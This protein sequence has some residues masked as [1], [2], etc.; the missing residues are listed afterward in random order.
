MALDPNLRAKIEEVNHKLRCRQYLF[1]DDL[2]A[3][4]PNTDKEA[5]DPD[6]ATHYK[7]MWPKVPKNSSKGLTLKGGV[8]TVSLMIKYAVIG[9]TVKE[10][11]HCFRYN[12]TDHAYALIYSDGS[13]DSQEESPH[14]M[15]RYD[16]EFTSPHMTAQQRVKAPP[17][18]IQVLHNLPRFRISEELNT[19]DEFLNT[20]RD[21]CFKETTRDSFAPNRRA[22]FGNNK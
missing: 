10:T 19:V 9:R 3:L 22:F 17:H 20:V 4:H 18:H 8:G 11:E 6:G 1:I 16:M 13:F 14:Y 5:T 15:F 21:T 7:V 12:N 2:T